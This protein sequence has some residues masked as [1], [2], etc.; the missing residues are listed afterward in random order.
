MFRKV[1]VKVREGDCL[2][3]PEKQP[4]LLCVYT[5]LEAYGQS[6]KEQNG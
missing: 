1:S 4:W 3:K 2:M 6:I 5:N